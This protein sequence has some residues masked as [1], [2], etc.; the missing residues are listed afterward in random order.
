MFIHCTSE[1]QTTTEKI[2]AAGDILKERK[3]KNP[4]QNKNE[5]RRQWISDDGR[6]DAHAADKALSDVILNCNFF[7]S[8]PRMEFLVF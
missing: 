4:K 6:G 5:T 8:P 2:Y 1:R 3:K 7:F